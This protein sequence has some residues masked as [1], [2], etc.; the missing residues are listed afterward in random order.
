MVRL[1]RSLSWTMMMYSL[2]SISICLCLFA[3][4]TSAESGLRAW[5]RYAPVPCDEVCQASLPAK[6]ISLDRNKSSP[7]YTA[8]I[9]VQ[10]GLE[11][12]FNWRV[13]IVYGSE[14]GDA[15]SVTIGT[16]LA[17]ADNCNSSVPQLED[18]AFYLGVGRA[19]R[20]LGA[21]ARGALY[22]A[23]EY[24]SLLGQ[25]NHI[26]TTYTSTPHAPIRW[27]N[28]WDNLDGSIERGYGGESIFFADGGVVSDLDRAVEYARLLASIRVNGIVVN[29]V[30]ANACLLTDDNINGVARIADAFRPYGVQVGIALNFASPRDLDG[31][32]TFDPL[33][34]GVV[35]WWS[36]LTARIYQRIPDLAGYL[37]KADS[38]DQPGPL[39]YNRTLADG[40]NLFARAL[41]PYHGVLMYR[42]FVY[43]N[44]L[45]YSDWKA[46]RAK[47]AVEYF[48]PLDGQFEENVVV[49]IKYGP[50]DFQVREPTSPL[51]ANLRETNT[52]IELEVSQEYLGQ[53]CHLVYL[54]PLWK[55]VL[56]FDLRVDG[57]KSQVRDVISGKTFNRTLGGWAA[58]V[59]VG[60]NTTWLGSHL[61]MSNLYAYGRLSWDPLQDPKDILRD[62]IRLTFGSNQDVLDIIMQMSMASW[63]AYENY[64]GNLGEQTL[65]DILYT[66]Y[67]PNP[68]SQDHNG[69]GQWTRA[70]NHA[71]GM[72]RTIGTGTGY[73]G[74]YPVD[75]ARMYEDITTTPD[76]L[77]LWFHHVNY[78]H[79]LQSGK[80]VI[81]HF[82]DAHY[83]GAETAHVF[84]KMWESLQDK[85]D[86]ERYHEV[87]TRLVYQA[88]HSIVWRDAIVD[89]YYNL[90][91]IP[92]VAGRVGNHPW[93]M[94]AESMMLDGYEVYAVDPFETAS[95]ASAIITA[96]NST[97]GSAVARINMPPGRYNL[98]V[99]YFDLYGGQ[100]SWTVYLNERQIGQWSGN[101]EDVLGHDP[102]IYLDGHS[103]RRITFRGVEVQSGD[104]VFRIVGES[105]GIEPAAVDYV[106]FL[107]EDVVD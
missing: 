52:A 79:P 23:F 73:A 80:S 84:V 11:R 49:Q 5:L 98:A 17:Y 70:D 3:L 46:D 57:K 101:A 41:Q 58:V 12:M 20:L 94:E 102:S 28:Q 29:N 77:L 59:N 34:D 8:G 99:N 82:Y 78:T 42:A 69:W 51:F 50:I 21:N 87:L 19:T 81:Q 63:P 53:Q 64:T 96:T 4:R 68:A 31:P 56:D 6:I 24:L 9:E 105:D 27:V 54:P 18:D 25:G 48:Q 35:S 22:A 107:P 55:T 61:A 95:N 2:L 72:D 32:D 33:D 38:E 47:A 36:N 13:P 10:H 40:A 93:R 65:T 60:T 76:D 89:F 85:I 92:D 83:G 16:V 1:I 75:I 44:H 106:A 86:P 26:A 90:S 100:S 67:G 104:G 15:A 37:V 66:H 30:N 39:T 91:G 14:C 43:N 7:V 45:N 103:A 97:I 74:Q 62:W 71:I 88:G